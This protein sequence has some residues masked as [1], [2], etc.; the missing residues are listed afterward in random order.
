M[1]AFN[2]SDRLKAKGKVMGRATYTFVPRSRILF[3]RTK[4]RMIQLVYGMAW[5]IERLLCAAIKM[6][7]WAVGSAAN[8]D[9]AQQERLRAEKNQNAPVPLDDRLPDVDALTEWELRL[10]V[11]YAKLS[12]VDQL[13]LMVVLE[14]GAWFHITRIDGTQQ[15]ALVLLQSKQ[16]GHSSRE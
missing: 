8:T 11:A 15:L 4:I 16:A 10:L 13:S 5:V 14:R 1:V 3:C 9:R 7:V 6:L 12:P 2:C